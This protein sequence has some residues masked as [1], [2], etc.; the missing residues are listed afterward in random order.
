MTLSLAFTA[1]APAPALVVVSV[2]MPFLAGIAVSGVMP[3]I[4]SI[5]LLWVV[6]FMTILPTKRLA[7]RKNACWATWARRSIA[8]MAEVADLAVHRVIGADGRSEAETHGA[9]WSAPCTADGER[10]MAR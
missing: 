2:V 7:A 1:V 10:R 3:I 6:A 5:A 4:V 8:P 9:A